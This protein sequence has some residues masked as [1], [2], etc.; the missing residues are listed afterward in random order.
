MYDVLSYLQTDAT[1]PKVVRPTVLGAVASVLAVVCKRMQQLPTLL[2]P[3]VCIVERIQYPPRRPCVMQVRGPKNVGRG[4]QTD[5]TL[6]RYASVI[7]ETKEML[8]V[9]CPKF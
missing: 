5:P 7:T 1:T 2:R 4:V 8:R 9:V 6:L 3:A